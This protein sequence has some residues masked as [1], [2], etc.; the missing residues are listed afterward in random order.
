[1]SISVNQITKTFG[2]QTVL[3]NVSFSVSTGEIVGLLGPNGAGKSTLM[4]IITGYIKQSAGSIEINSESTSTPHMNYRRLVGYLP[5]NN[6]VYHDMFVKEYLHWVANVYGLKSG[7]KR[8]QTLIEQTGIGREQ[9]KKIGSL[10][11]GY[12][13]R[14]GLAQALMNDPAV[15]ILDEPTTGLDPNQLAEIRN[16]I[17]EVGTSKTIILSTHIMQEVEAICDRVV[18]L[19]HGHVIAD[20]PTEQVRAMASNHAQTVRCEFAEA[21]T[22]NDLRGIPHVER[23]EHGPDGTLLLYASGAEDIRP[24]IFDHAKKHDLTLLTLLQESQRLEDIF[25]DLTR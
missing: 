25:Q 15:L 14:V 17:A 13:Q 5:E 16:L 2:E 9:Y 18:I 7:A 8:V 24:H 6:P 20:G 10:S 19:H 21:I 1:M 11:K 23:V 3:D 12:K 22:P 4:K